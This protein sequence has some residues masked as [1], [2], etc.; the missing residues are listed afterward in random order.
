MNNIKRLLTFLFIVAV[1]ASLYFLL[2]NNKVDHQQNDTEK[3][4]IIILSPH[5]DDAVLSLGGFMTKREG[6]FLVMTFFTQRPAEVMHTEWDNLSGFS[7]SD[8]A[9]IARTK[10]NKDALVMFDAHIYNYEYLDFQY[11]TEDQDSAITESITR[12][13]IS[14]IESYSEREI[15]IYGPGIFGEEI[16]HPD[17]KIVHDAFMNVLKTKI[18]FNM[19]FFIYED[20]PYIQYFEMANLGDFNKYLTKQE[21]LDFNK[22]VIRLN[23]TQLEEKKSSIYAYISQQ[24]AFLALGNDLGNMIAKFNQQRCHTFFSTIYA[25]EV[26]HSPSNKAR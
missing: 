18:Q 10:E 21:H 15:H 6:E 9:I 12:D 26:V 13:I 5:F 20:F 24:K 3:P 14:I 17:H 7:N 11:R 2:N 23:K 8:E 19:K 1:V 4:L 22:V 16:T 25:C